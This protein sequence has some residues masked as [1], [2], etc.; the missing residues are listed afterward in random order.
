M[1]APLSVQPK[2][3]E[4]IRG[5]YFQIVTTGGPNTPDVS[6]SY[7]LLPMHKEDSSKKKNKTIEINSDGV[8]QAVELGQIKVVAKSIGNACL[9]FTDRTITLSE[10]SAFRCNSEN[11]VPRVYSEDFLVVKVVE[12]RSI[13]LQTPL[14]SIRQGNE[15]PIF[16]MGNEF[17]LNP[18]NFG[19]CSHLKFTWKINDQQ[20][21]SLHHPLLFSS[22]N[23]PENS[24]ASEDLYPL[25]E[26]SFSLRFLARKPGTVRVSVRVEFQQ[27]Y[28]TNPSLY[29]SDTIDIVVFD[30]AHFTHF[31]L[32]YLKFISPQ[33]AAKNSKAQLE[34][35]QTR[36]LLM[37]PG[38]QLQLKTNMDKL[39]S[40]MSYDLAFPLD[41]A[42]S[43]HCNNNTIVVSKEGLISVKHVSRHQLKHAHECLATVWVT[44]YLSENQN[45]K[46]QR[47][48]YLIRVKPI[49]YSMLVVDKNSIVK[50]SDS[51]FSRIRIDAKSLIR[52][53]LVLNDAGIEMKW[54]VKYYDNLGEL[55]DVV[56]LSNEYL[57]NRND[58]VDL[59]Q[60]N[61]NLFGLSYSS[62]YAS[63]EQAVKGA[64]LA[65]RN[66]KAENVGAASQISLLANA[67]ENSFLTRTIKP[68]RFIMEL[69]PFATS[70]TFSRDYVGLFVEQFD[71]SGRSETGRFD[72]IEANIG[73]II[74]LNQ[75]DNDDDEDDDF[76]GESAQS[77]SSEKPSWTSQTQSIVKLVGLSDSAFSYSHFGVC[78]NEG[79]DV[80]KKVCA[81]WF[82]L[83]VVS[84]FKIEILSQDYSKL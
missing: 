57:I 48:P 26:N 60:L 21:A 23:T 81:F 30:K 35:G 24:D 72:G 74:C 67:V 33:F 55:F 53:R 56:S 25:F 39:A 4:L 59:S 8:I 58:L 66:E 20:I 49:V 71:G 11:R 78:L 15:M 46:R 52:N 80:L 64:G 38:S 37:S 75:I 16:V 44:V 32:A 6:I 70:Y 62:L 76:D 9:P 17:S 2:Y 40:K 82:V 12:L 54:H 18:L 61:A 14:K 28:N 84:I 13:N 19:S 50:I 45:S 3:I 65:S 22:K 5:A 68:G 83:F 41:H 51:S 79:L 73:D 31:P 77:A 1:Y 27:G 42:E 36:A 10:M 43:K 7:A 63:D 29:L 47:L 69:T 34:L